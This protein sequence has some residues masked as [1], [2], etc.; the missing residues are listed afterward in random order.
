MITIFA[1]AGIGEVDPDTNLPAVLMEAI[2]ADP[3]GPLC[4]G[5][6]LVVTS[7]IISKA[8]GRRLPADQRM[9]AIS[10]E[11]TRTVARRGPMRIVRT[12]QGL[13]IAAAGVDNSNVDPASILL[14]PLDPDA[15]ARTLRNQLLERYG[16]AVGVIISDTAG[17]AWRIGQTD[18]AIGSAGVRVVDRYEGRTDPYGNVLGV[19]AV[20]VADEIAAAADLVKSKLAGRPVAVVRGLRAHL[21]DAATDTA[22]TDLVRSAEEELFG[23]GS[24]EAVLE[25]VL[26]AY[27]HGDRFE[28]VIDHDDAMLADA[29]LAVVGEDGDRAELIRA[30]I[31][32]AVE[33]A[34]HR[35]SLLHP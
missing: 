15:S 12:R 17:R 8:E 16:V 22:A 2:A 23:R 35:P 33:G 19:T 3:G 26:A 14:L 29:V 31:A 4:D 13:T 21:S 28:Q 18:Q 7:K 27:G 9:A 11:S 25:A 10:A 20:A 5:D 32:A 34:G 30:V 1:P 24:R 6:I